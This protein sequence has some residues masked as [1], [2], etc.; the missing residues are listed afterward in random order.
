MSP[1]TDSDA[2]AR[3]PT[4]RAARMAV[5]GTWSLTMLAGFV[6]MLLGTSPNGSDVVLDLEFGA[7]PG[8]GTYTKKIAIA[9]RTSGSWTLAKPVSSCMCVRV[10]VG[11]SFVTAGQEIQAT[12]EFTLPAEGPSQHTIAIAV[13]D[14]S[15][16]KFAIRIMVSARALGSPHVDPQVI[17]IETPTERV[18]ER[19]VIV[20]VPATSPDYVDAYLLTS[21][22]PLIQSCDP[23]FSVGGAV[24]IVSIEPSPGSVQDGRI[25]WTTKVRIEPAVANL[26][27][28]ARLT[29]EIPPWRLSVPPIMLR[30]SAREDARAQSVIGMKCNRSA[31]LQ[32]YYACSAIIGV[33]GIGAQAR[34]QGGHLVI[35]SG[36]DEGVSVVSVES[37]VG[38]IDLMVTVYK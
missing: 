36:N 7:L 3:G 17:W 12:V 8:N 37:E 29:L 38:P 21:G 28:L 16:H 19:E 31:T 34:V 11:S 13:D 22:I 10:A 4:R 26:R 2:A 18:E 23:L 25:V 20:S 27:A 1:S 32:S 35:D 14:S 24:P 5:V 30:W 15:G 6:Y 9:N 33:A